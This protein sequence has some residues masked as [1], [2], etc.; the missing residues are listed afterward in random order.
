MKEQALTVLLVEDNPGDARLIREMLRE[1]YGDRCRVESVDRLA[2]AFES[3]SGGIDV[4]LL[5]LSLPDSQGIETFLRLHEHT[6]EVPVVVLTGLDDDALARQAV[7][8]GAQDYLPK[9]EANPHGLVRSVLYAVERSRGE[10][11]RARLLAAEQAAHAE[12]EAQRARLQAVLESA[13]HGIMFV[14]AATG[15]LT[16]N[17][18]AERLFGRPLL[19]E[20]D[21]TQYLGQVCS[22]GGKPVS[23]EELPLQRAL[24]DQGATDEELLLRRPDGCDVPVLCSSAPVRDGA[25]RIFGAVALFQDITSLKELERLREEWTSVIAHDLRQ[26]VTAIS[27]F[28]QALGALAERD[29]TLHPVQS[30]AQ[31]IVE[32]TRQLDRMIGDLLDMSRLGAGRLQVERVPIDVSDLV[33]RVVGRLAELADGRSVEVIVREQLPHVAGDPG[34]LEQILVNLVSNAAKYSDPGT[35]IIV[36]VEEKG[37]HVEV[38]VTNRGEGIPAA[39]VPHLF[40]R[41]YRSSSARVGG[42]PG[43][44]LGLYITRELVH[45]HGGRIWVESL[46]GEATTFRFTL[47]MASTSEAA[48]PPVG[49]TSITL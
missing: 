22:T 25:G 2:A 29:E 47:P 19:P 14:D 8:A 32:A 24:R 46:P 16:S 18:A 38:A 30:Q 34:R 3:L 33:H 27:L 4:V 31:R 37:E 5:D 10:A 1:G 35:S 44:G 26:P 40:S 45:A 12:A 6:P 49:L 36:R 17:P 9:G 41:F 43:L 20:E 42:L 11:E 48:A 15:R 28:A 13:G 23:F 7:Q 39:E 21:V